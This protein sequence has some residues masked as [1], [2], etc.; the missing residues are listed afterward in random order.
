MT[1][2]GGDA[3]SMRLGVGE[4][5]AERWQVSRLTDLV[6]TVL[7]DERDPSGRAMIL[8]VD[9][10]SSSGK[11]TLS[12]RIAKLLEGV[13]VVHTDDVAWR[14]CRFG[15][16]ELM[17]DGVLAPVH[18]SVA[19][20]LRPPAW[21]QHGRPGHIVVPRGARLVV[22]EGVGSARRE[23]ASFLDGVLWV[24]AD[25]DEVDRRNAARVA[26]GETTAEGV[27]GWMAEEYPFVEAQR[28]WAR[29][30][31][32]ISGNPAL[33]YDPKTEVVMAPGPLW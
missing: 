33:P 32:W 4:P 28:P 22:L 26:A 2:K 8:A 18:R 15:W 10:R 3:M 23:L 20:R 11:T 1:Q 13:C 16:A 30:K 25:L 6:S 5:A 17:I 9:G 7:P 31:A 21:A 14:H 27:A 24:Q 29:A 12:H 19:V